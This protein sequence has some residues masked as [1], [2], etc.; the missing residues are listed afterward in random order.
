[1]R[2]PTLNGQRQHWHPP[3]QLAGDANAITPAPARAVLT[4]ARGNHGAVT[5]AQRSA[6]QW[7]STIHA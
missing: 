2:L 6:A 1:M 7:R 5:V 3:R 4:V